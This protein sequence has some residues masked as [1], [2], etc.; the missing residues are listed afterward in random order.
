MQPLP[1]ETLERARKHIRLFIE[2]YTNEVQGLSAMTYKMHSL[3]HLID[4]LVKYL[5]H[6]EF[7]SSYKYENFHSKWKTWLRSGNK[8]LEQIR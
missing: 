6:M 1:P 4:D 7:L 2:I 8:P 5:C 3:I